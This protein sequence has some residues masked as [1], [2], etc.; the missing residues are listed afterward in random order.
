MQLMN[1]VAIA[2]TT[3]LIVGACSK[4]EKPAADTAAAKA[5]DSAAVAPAPAA[6]APLALADVAGSWKMHNVPA[7]GTDTTATDVVLV[8]TADTT[9]WSITLPGGTKVPLHVVAAGDSIVATSDV[10]SSV[11]RKGVKVHTVSTLR[12][13]NS[14]LAGQTVAH[15]HSKTDSV[16]VLNA[17]ATKQ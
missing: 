12:L 4:S 9:G 7:S 16:L 17:T 1:R 14:A 11:R 13:Q 15:Y 10:Y 6:P 5:P 3:S 2:L 8:A